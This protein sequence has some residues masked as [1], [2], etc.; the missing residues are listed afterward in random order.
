MNQKYSSKDTSVNSAK[1]PAIYNLR[2]EQLKEKEILDIGGGK[3][4]IAKV[5]GAQNGSQ[6]TIYDKFNRSEKEN[7]EALAVQK[8]DVAIISNVLNVICEPEIRQSLVQL[9]TEKAPIT[10]ITVY[11]GNG[12]GVG[13]VSKKDCWQENRKTKDYVKEIQS[14][15]PEMSVTRSGKVIEIRIA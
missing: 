3:Y 1:L 14:Y 7:N 2:S 5:W 9:A 13:A 11:E 12:S 8:Y 4:D 6:V 15:V 10:Y